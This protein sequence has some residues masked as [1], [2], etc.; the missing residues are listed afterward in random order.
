MTKITF[1]TPIAEQEFKN[2]AK[3]TGVTGDALINLYNEIRLKEK[4]AADKNTNW[5]V[6]PYAKN[7]FQPPIDF[8]MQD[9]ILHFHGKTYLNNLNTAKQNTKATRQNQLSTDA[10]NKQTQKIN[11]EQ[12]LITFRDS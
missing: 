10:Q 11:L 6:I 4:I 9:L 7:L 5:D 2:V 8:F 12:A 1:D 3:K